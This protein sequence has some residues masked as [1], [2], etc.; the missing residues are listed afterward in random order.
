MNL[1]ETMLQVV[2]QLRAAAEVATAGPRLLVCPCAGEMR[3]VDGPTADQALAELR[4]AVRHQAY[5]LEQAAER[6]RAV[7]PSGAWRSPDAPPVVPPGCLSV[8][9]LAVVDDPRLQ[10][11]GERPFVEKVAYWPAGRRWTA[12][13]QAPGAA[14][15]ADFP[16]KVRCWQH[17]PDL[18]ASWSPL[19][20]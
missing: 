3:L 6:L 18:P 11:A 14:D 5:D 15:A 17:M 8:E 7:D 10:T 19:W 12:T 9:V 1:H 16:V 2:Q 4:R 13:Y 20:H